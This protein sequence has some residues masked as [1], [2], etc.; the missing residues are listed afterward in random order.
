[1]AG[2]QC[3]QARNSSEAVRKSNLTPRRATQ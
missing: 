2:C 1:L 3:W